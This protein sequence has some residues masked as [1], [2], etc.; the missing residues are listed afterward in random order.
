MSLISRPFLALL[1]RCRSFGLARWRRGGLLMAL[2]FS[3]F[4]AHAAPFAYLA[5][6]ITNN[7]SVIDM[8]TYLTTSTM[9]LAPGSAAVNVVT[10]KATKKV[11]VGTTNSIVIVDST[12]N[13]TV[14]NIPLAANL[15]F[16]GYSTES[17][18]LIV[19]NAGTKAYALSTGLVSVIDLVTKTVVATITVPA[20][21]SGMALESD[22]DTL[23]V[24]TGYFSGPPPSIVVIDALLNKI[25]RV[26]ATGTLVPTHIAVHP[27]DL[28]LF[29]A[30]VHADGSSNLFYAVLD[31]ATATVS[32]VAITA[33]PGVTLARQFNNFVFNQDGSRMY[34]APM[35]LSTTT[36]PV[37]EVNTANGSATRVLSIPSGFADEHYFPKMAASFA[38]GKF[39]LMFSLVEHMHHHPAEPPRRIVFVDGISGVVL[40]DIAYPSSSSF[41]P[42]VADILD[43][44]AAPVTGKVAT[45]TT[46]RASTNPPLR[47][48]TPLVLT[49]AVTGN[50]PTGQ[51]VFQFIAVPPSAAARAAQPVS[52]KVRRALDQGTASLSLPACNVRWT[53][54][55]LRRVVCSNNFEITA[56]YRGDKHN[57]KS[58]SAAL[59]ETR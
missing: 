43:S 53:D 33:S 28:R 27:D 22:G 54:L 5:D 40:K 21:A 34:M 52:V 39:T 11:Y 6:R 26:V 32:E 35:T 24:S 30:G 16:A 7:L 3:G 44:V 50:N 20:D 48:T 2:L 42:I 36:L 37:L 38:G 23:Y 1:M 59:V 55:A 25:E 17:Q 12:T 18:S 8:A 10:N 51:M 45:T 58:T 31:A 15:L 4:A 29:I 46:L 47:P 13:L 41:T 57:R 14:G 56:R 19:N 9:P 49:A